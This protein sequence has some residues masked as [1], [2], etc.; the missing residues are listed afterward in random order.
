MAS[1]LEQFA[2]RIED[3]RLEPR[4]AGGIRLHGENRP[5][6]VDD[7][8]GQPVG[9]GMD[10]AIKGLIEQPLAQFESA[11]DPAGEKAAADR[12]GGVAVEDARSE[13]GMRV[14]HR[15]AERAGVGAP[16]GDETAGCERF[17][18]GV[19]GHFVRVDPRVAG[20]G[21]PVPSGEQRDRWSSCRIVRGGLVRRYCIGAH[22]TYV[23]AATAGGHREARRCAL[24]LRAAVE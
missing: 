17:G 13:Q 10:E 19:H 5:E 23:V 21:A 4:H 9:F 6:P 12:P 16:Q 18:R 24:P 20:F 2:E 8:A 1:G 15:D 11:P 22:P 3:D 7:E 14:E